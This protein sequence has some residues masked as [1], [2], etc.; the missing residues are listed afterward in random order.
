MIIISLKSSQKVIHYIQCLRGLASIEQAL[1]GLNPFDSCP[2]SEP[3]ILFYSYALKINAF[4]TRESY[5]TENS[6]AY[7]SDVEVSC[8]WGI[9][10]GY[11]IEK[12]YCLFKY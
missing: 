1:E 5:E 11:L 8:Q 2:S 9:Q 12:S 7:L 6:L 3:L 4:D 10:L